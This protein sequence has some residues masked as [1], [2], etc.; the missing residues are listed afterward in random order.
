MPAT[1]TLQVGS[2]APSF[3]P[4]VPDG[5]FIPV[6]YGMA[7]DNGGSDILDPSSVSDDHIFSLEDTRCSNI[8]ACLAYTG[9]PT[10]G[11]AVQLFGR[12]NPD[13]GNSATAGQWHLC[14][15]VQGTAT[16]SNCAIP[17]T[18]RASDTTVTYP[19]SSGA[20]TSYSATHCDI[21]VNAWDRQSFNEFKFG[22]RTEQT[23]GTA[24]D[25][26]L[27]AKGG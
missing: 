19:N 10:T 18:V 5:D 12:Y 21:K 6:R 17:F 7:Q 2:D 3:V 13:I 24:A 15:N 25:S 27:L 1:K 4:C 8:F 14:P 26:V 22:V 11:G 9:S 16:Y 20:S 23:G